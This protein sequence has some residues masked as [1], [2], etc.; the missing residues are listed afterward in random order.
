MLALKQ[1]LGASG[2]HQINADAANCNNSASSGRH[3]SSSRNTASLAPVGSY[4]ATDTDVAH[5]R[6]S[7]VSSYTQPPAQN[8][9][10]SVSMPS[11][12]ADERVLLILSDDVTR[13]GGVPV[14]GRRVPHAS[15]KA[16]AANG[17]QQVLVTP[18]T[19]QQHVVVGR[20]SHRLLHAQQQQ[21]QID[22]TITPT[23][24]NTFERVECHDF[25]VEQQ[26]QLRHT[27]ER[28]ARRAA[29]AAIQSIG[30]PS[31][32][33]R[34]STTSSHEPAHLLHTIDK[35]I[36]GR[37]QHRKQQQQQQL[38]AV[39]PANFEGS[40]FAGASQRHPAGAQQNADAAQQFNY[41]DFA[42]QDALA[43]ERELKHSSR[44]RNS[45]TT[46]ISDTQATR[47]LARKQQ[48]QPM[49]TRN[50]SSICHAAL[51][52]GRNK[53]SQRRELAAE[54][55]H[56]ECVGCS[57]S[58]GQQQPTISGCV[59]CDMIAAAAAASTSLLAL[60]QQQQQQR[61]RAHRSATRHASNERA[62]RSTAAAVGNRQQATRRAASTHRQQ[63]QP[64]LLL[65]RSLSNASN[66]SSSDSMSVRSVDVAGD[67]D[68]DESTRASSCCSPAAAATKRQ[69]RA[70]TRPPAVPSKP[71]R[72]LLERLAASYAQAYAA[73]GSQP[74]P[75]LPLPNHHHHHN[76]K[77]KRSSHNKAKHVHSNNKYVE[78]DASDI[79]DD[80]EAAHV[81]QMYESLAAELKAKLGNPKMGPIL[82]PPKDYDTISRRQGK[83]TGIEL[84]RSTNPQLV[85]PIAA[86]PAPAAGG[87]SRSNSSS[88]VCSMSIGASASPLG[89]DAECSSS[90][91]AGDE[92]VASDK[93]CATNKRRH[94]ASPRS[95][96]GASNSSSGSSGGN[97]AHSD[98]GHSSARLHSSSSGASSAGSTT[99]SRHKTTLAA[100]IK[101]Q[102]NASNKIDESRNKCASAANAKA[103]AT[104]TAASH[105]QANKHEKAQTTE[106]MSEQQ[107]QQRGQGLHNHNPSR[108]SSGVLWNGRV[109]IPLKV[110]SAKAGHTY[111]AT[112]QIIY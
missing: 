7:H 39:V 25:A 73:N 89:V 26:Q 107:Q 84:R 75:P 76:H 63:Q 15:S 37:K 87:V 38:L 72:A 66:L 6:L 86:T 4:L 36:D 42:A 80:D 71:S 96:S 108:V 52:G 95:D 35:H 102:D 16:A 94:L 92:L 9:P 3:K 19:H 24:A 59:E 82:L 91:T 64:Q 13:A 69:A 61:R 5:A 55:D 33:S 110:N 20:R 57:N 45:K 34:R 85:G 44:K 17:Q 48:Q 29:A 83:L 30:A 8:G 109:E 14:I 98:S 22:A 23:A 41:A 70:G 40:L 111:L 46:H 51:L 65:A 60:T 81:T 21:Q 56:F 79:D 67:D 2:A 78:L 49:A 58:G 47:R 74:P 103:T 62:R 54:P 18:P 31:S 68:A 1:M 100:T 12:A 53:Q 11:G 10:L 88:G 97:A 50:D 43:L 112:K 99:G 27:S 90:S 106:A 101:Q 32:S 93:S 104:A 105:K 77:A 28:R